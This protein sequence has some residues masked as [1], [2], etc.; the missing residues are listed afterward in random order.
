M[1]DTAVL[2]RQTEEPAGPGAIA[3]SLTSVNLRLFPFAKQLRSRGHRVII[4]GLR[5]LDQV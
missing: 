2:E 5:D 4:A 1:S 3:S